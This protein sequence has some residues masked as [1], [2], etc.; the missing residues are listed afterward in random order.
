MM[1]LFAVPVME[2]MARLSRAADGRHAQHRLPAAQ[3]LPLLDLSGRRHPA[4]GRLRRST[5]GP[6]SA[7]SPTCRCP[8]PQY[9][10]GKRADIWAQM[11]TFTEIVGAGR[12]GRDRRHRLQ[13]ARAR[14][15]ARPHPAVRL[16]DA[17]HRLHGHLGDAGD[18]G[19]EHV[20]DP[21]PAGRHAFLQSGRGRRRAAVAAPVLVLRP[22][23]GLHHLPA[24]GRHDLD[25]RADLRAAAGVR[26]PAAGAGA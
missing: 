6:T 23:G 1:F 25:D 26:L 15:V 17:G 16:G 20:A 11:I 7:G 18:H 24:G 10:A 3:R 12:R 14:H 19:G 22:S 13:A 8:G 9:G 21:R 4:L 2:A 5:W